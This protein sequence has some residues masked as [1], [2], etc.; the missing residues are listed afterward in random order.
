MSN[1]QQEGVTQNEDDAELVSE[2]P[3]PPNY[4]TQA[5]SLTPPP[6]PKEALV[7]S[8]KKAVAQ[9]RAREIEAKSKFG[10]DA[11]ILGGAV[12]DFEEQMNDVSDEGPT[13]AVFGEG[14]Y[15]EVNIMTSCLIHRP[16]DD[17]GALDDCIITLN[18]SE[19]CTY[20]LY[21]FFG[22]L[23]F[24]LFVSLS[25]NPYILILYFM[26]HHTNNRILI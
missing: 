13:V 14:C 15:V 23:I 3:P 5:S 8:T 22:N 19:L 17:L 9:R 16:F 21:F 18:E 2:F 25:M 26:L 20:N 10:G 24:L 1:H 6:I 4:F 12:P 7:R 11:G